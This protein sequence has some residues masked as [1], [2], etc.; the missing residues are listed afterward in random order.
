MLSK[1]NG[2]DVLF[3]AEDF[4]QWVREKKKGEKN[5]T[6]LEWVK[7][8]KPESEYLHQVFYPNITAIIHHRSILFFFPGNLQVY[9]RKKN[10]LVFKL[11]KVKAAGV[12]EALLF[13]SALGLQYFC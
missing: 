11:Q 8:T 7:N 5:T 4:P 3:I 1:L 6:K 9:Q 10:A 12:Q 2:G 13:F